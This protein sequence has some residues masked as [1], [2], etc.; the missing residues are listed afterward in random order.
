VAGLNSILKLIIVMIHPRTTNTKNNFIQI[1]SKRE[2]KKSSQAHEVEF[3]IE[4]NNLKKNWSV[5]FLFHALLAQEK[6]SQSD[7][8]FKDI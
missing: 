4:F 8:H 1:N 2:S 6:K 5:L 3:S 7:L